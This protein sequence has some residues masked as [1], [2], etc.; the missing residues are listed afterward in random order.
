MK[1]YLRETGTHTCQVDI[2]MLFY[3]HVHHLLKQIEF[4]TVCEAI[5]SNIKLYFIT[6][7]PST[8]L[9]Y[10]RSLWELMPE[11]NKHLIVLNIHFHRKILYTKHKIKATNLSIF[12]ILFL[13]HQ[14][15]SLLPIRLTAIQKPS[16]CISKRV[17]SQ[18]R[19]ASCPQKIGFKTLHPT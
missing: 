15:A 7:L 17:W 1:K 12:L 5:E 4:R 9:S 14:S 6:F 10:H 3:M 13:S 16:P 2:S 8:Q 19:S 18:P 11:C